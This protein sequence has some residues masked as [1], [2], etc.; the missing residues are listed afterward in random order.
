[1]RVIGRRDIVEGK[2]HARD[3]LRQK[4]KQESGTE[5]VGEPRTA[6]N[7]L[8]KRGSEQGV[9]SGPAVYPTPKSSRGLGHKAS[10][11]VRGRC[12]EQYSLPYDFFVG[13]ELAEVLES[14]EELP[15]L[16]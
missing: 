7:R 16:L 15:I 2:K 8:I 10:V 11:F 14:R 6:R 4:Y 5:Y 9:Q 12:S 1:M 13:D 3:D